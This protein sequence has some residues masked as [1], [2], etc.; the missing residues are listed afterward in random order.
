MSEQPV[1]LL[2]DASLCKNEHLSSVST[3]V[4]RD[5]ALLLDA[6][7]TIEEQLQRRGML[8]ITYLH[9]FN[10]LWFQAETERN[11]F[12]WRS[13]YSL[14]DEDEF[15]FWIDP[16]ALLEKRLSLLNE[17][18]PKN[19]FVNPL[20]GL[21]PL[22]PESV[23]QEVDYLETLRSHL[24]RIIGHASALSELGSELIQERDGFVRQTVVL[25]AIPKRR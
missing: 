18:D 17:S 7:K 10:P 6:L 21:A 2:I 24:A 13:G 19:P 5:R 22:D 8:P 16:Q 25:P 23:R 15:E 11:V 9:T 12:L 4:N 1:N 3:T 14:A 20:W